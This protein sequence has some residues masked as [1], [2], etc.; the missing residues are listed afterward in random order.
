MELFT[1]SSFLF[2]GSS[3]KKLTTPKA[4][5]TTGNSVIAR[6]EARESYLEIFKA[7][8]D[9]FKE[10]RFV[11]IFD[12]FEHVGKASTDFFLNFIKFLKPQE[13]FHIILSFRTD[14]R[15]WNDTSVRN[16]YENLEQ[17]L[18]YDLDAKKISIEGLSAEDIGKWIK[19]VRG[20]SLPLIPSLQR[21]RKNSAGLPIL[22]DEWIRSS[23]NLNYE[24]ISMGKKREM[25]CSQEIRRQNS[26]SE[27]DQVRLYKMSILLQPP[28]YKRLGKYLETDPVKPFLNRL[29]ENRVFDERFKWFRHELVQRCFEEDLDP[30]ERRSY[31]ERAGLFFESLVEENRQADWQNI[32][33][34]EAIE[35]VSSTLVSYAYHLHMAGYHE[36]SLE[37]NTMCAIGASYRGELDVAE[38]CYKRAIDDAKH[39]GEF[40]MR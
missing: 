30:E 24:E 18:L 8:A 10:K 19:Q 9:E 20:I 13:R 29:I 39:L 37:Y 5:V 16:M 26:L 11:L 7:I 32:N 33:K 40:K 21:I 1:I 14:D 22:L 12:Q 25:L 27:Q 2:C 17:T 6:N 3:Q 15:T 35:E 23:E 34:E 28:K 31:H 38:R 36:K 4:R